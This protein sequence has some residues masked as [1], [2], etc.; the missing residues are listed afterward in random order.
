MPGT[1]FRAIAYITVFATGAAGLI[2][3]VTWYR[4]LSRLIGSDAIATAIILGVFLGGLSVGYLI[5]G[6]LTTHIRRYFEAYAV[7]EGII[8]IWCL[9]FPLIFNGV[10]ALSRSWS[11]SPPGLILIQGV[12]TAILLMGIPTICM[13]GTIPL[14]TRG[15][16]ATVTESTRVHA[17]IYGINTAGAFIGTLA[18]GFAL[19]PVFGLPGT[20]MLT[21]TL[22]F[23]AGVIFLILPRL[24]KTAPHLQTKAAPGV[25][26]SPFAREPG[27]LRYTPTALYV[28][29]FLSGFYVMTLENVLIRM[30]SLS[31]GSST[32]SFSIIVSVFILAIAIGSFVV[33]G[34]NR[35]PRQLLF[36]NQLAILIFLVI[37]YFTLDVWPYAHHLIRISFQSNMA[38]F[39]A[40]HGA[41]FF[42]LACLL[43]LPVGLMGAT[44][45]LIFHELK[46]DL[47]RVGHHSGM[48]L[49]WN[50]AGNLV[51]S[52]SA[53]ILLYVILDNAGVFAVALFLSA[54]AVLTAGAGLS[55]RY[56]AVGIA[57]MVLVVLIPLIHGRFDPSR[58]VVG[59][60]RIRSPLPFSF[61]GPERFHTRL[62]AGFDLEFYEDGPVATVAVTRDKSLL[63]PFQEPSMALMINGKSD[64]STI[65]DIYTLR[66]L[67]H[68]PALLAERREN[69]MVVGLG[70]GVTA[71]ELL[72]YPDI[73]QIDVAEISPAVV[74]ALP[75]FKPFIHGLHEDPRVNIQLGD[76]FRIIGRSQKKW[77]IIISEPSNPWVT[78]VDALFSRDFYRLVKEHLTESGLLMQWIHTTGASTAMI[79]MTLN[80]LRQEFP[81]SRVFIAGADL[82]ILASK[83]PVSCRDLTSAERT[84]ASTAGVKASLADIRISS[85]AG[86]LVRERWT[87]SFLADY[88]QGGGIQT[89]DFPGLHYLA[90]KDFFI[91]RDL[92]PSIFMDNRTTAYGNDYLFYKQCA[93]WQVAPDTPEAFEALVASTVSVFTNE[94][95][96]MTD[97]LLM[98]AFLSDSQAYPLPWEK[99][100][101][102]GI[103]VLPFIINYTADEEEWAHINLKGAPLRV[104]AET[105][106]RHVENFR[107]WMTPYPMDGLVTLLRKGMAESPDP[108]D[109][110]WFT[111]ELARLLKQERVDSRTIQEILQHLVRDKDGNLLINEEDL[112]LYRRLVE[113]A[114]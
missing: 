89:L 114:K 90:G 1:L 104:R 52:L 67:A 92:D 62:N 96:P 57:A 76:A 51:G 50:T 6:R 74:K 72:L 101:Q 83:R 80:T 86:I 40:Y 12:G 87:P 37:I 42:S 73:T 48:L 60:F 16:S 2:Y 100:K 13:G 15:F 113:P 14:L 31:L 39:W 110:N 25:I 49:S 38:G 111:L 102:F 84:L 85:L 35:I 9:S 17:K 112:Y 69:V 11:F 20:M 54:A 77:D 26:S 97:A 5:I 109:R 94:P 79:D 10:E 47:N 27:R 107:S 21:S 28:I 45:P 75:L 98:R 32:Y 95:S 36:F 41:V 61:D 30:T 68:I 106:L 65:G 59:T 3:Q 88:V 70:T 53:G 81:E 23:A 108:G 56:T 71:G 99:E 43:V 78:G 24:M 18:A 34:L 105:L 91:G 63:G 22:N 66:L 7:L 8:G 4:Y 19:I 58:F 82:L 44:I 29:A 55:R 33:S 64:S 93:E 103:D 46:Q